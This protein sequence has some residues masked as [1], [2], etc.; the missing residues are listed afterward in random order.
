MPLL[1]RHAPSLAK[2][3][4]QLPEPERARVGALLDFFLDVR[5]RFTPEQGGAHLQ[6]EA[7]ALALWLEK[8][9]G[10]GPV[11]PRWQDLQRTVQE[12]GIPKRLL[13]EFVDGANL[14]LVKQRYRDWVQLRQHFRQTAAAPGL[15]IGLALGG[16]EESLAAPI[17]EAGQAW[18]ISQLLRTVPEQLDAGRILIPEED[19]EKYGVAVQDLVDR[20]P[21]EAL[22]ALAADYQERARKLVS[23]GEAAL[24]QVPAGPGRTWAAA[25]LED[26]AAA[27]WPIGDSRAL[28]ERET[29][30]QG[31]RGA[32]RRLFG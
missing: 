18:G 15:A 1:P 28:F 27:F 20:R 22:D 10:S 12:A 21:T 8:L 24:E 13:V 32:L 6:R 25:R 17:Q 14:S 31:L 19:L 4:R 23:A 2:S 11:E 3:L 29:R 30:P 5:L 9:Y 26:Q 7:L 16:R